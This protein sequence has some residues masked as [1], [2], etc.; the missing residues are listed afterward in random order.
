MRKYIGKNQNHSCNLSVP[1]SDQKQKK[2]PKI[3]KDFQNQFE[4]HFSGFSQ[5]NN[6]T[7]RSIHIKDL[8]ANIWGLFKQLSDISIKESA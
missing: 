8:F 3:T 1:S 7:K 4:D 2:N 6:Q 5:M